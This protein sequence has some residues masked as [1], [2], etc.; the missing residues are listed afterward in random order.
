MIPGNVKSLLAVA[1]RLMRPGHRL[2]LLVTLSSLS[3]AGL[4]AAA[5]AE[6]RAYDAARN[7]FYGG[8][9]ERAEKEFGEFIKIHPDS[10]KVPEAVVLQAQCSYQQQ[11]LDEALALLRGR[12][13]GAGKLADEYRYWIAESLFQ[14]ADYAGAATAFAQV[15]SDFPNSA[16]RLAASL[17]EAYARFKAGELQQTVDLLSQPK[18]AFQQAAQNRMDDDLAVRGHLLL[19]EAYFGLKQFQRGQEVLIRLADRN[20]RP[21]LNWQRLYLLARLQSAGEQFDAALQTTTNLLGQLTA[22]TNLAALSLQADMS[23]LQA[24][25]FEQKGQMESAIQAYEKNL[26]PTVPMGRRR[27]AL[28]QT[29]RLTL[30]QNKIGE[31]G[32]RLESFVTQNPGDPLLDLLRLTLGELRL[33]EYYELA[34]EPRS[35]ATNLLQQAKTQFEQVIANANTQLVAKA[36]LDRGWYLWEL[37]RSDADTNRIS[38]SMLAFQAAADGLPRSEGQAVA[39][40]KRADCQFHLL[41]YAGAL[42]NYWA[43]VT[44]YPDLPKI[45]SDLVGLA[46]Y[47]IVRA[48]IQLGD[49]T[50][51]DQAVRRILADYRPGELNDRSLLLYGQALSRVSDPAGAR[52]FFADFVKRFPQSQMLPEVELAVARTYEE[53][54]NWAEAATLYDQWTA[55]RGE[56]VARPSVEFDRAWANSLAGNETNAYTLFTNFVA[57]FPAHPFAPQ[58]QYWVADYFYRLGGTNYVKAEENYQKVYQNTNWPPSELSFQ[59]RMM[60]GR[61]AFARQGYNAAANYFTSLINELAKLN[62]RPALLAEAYYALADTYVRN[63]E[64][65]PGSTNILDNYTEAIVALS[66]IP[67]EFPDKALV[68]LAWGQMGAY[69]AQLAALSHDPKDY[70]RATNAFTNALY[71][72]LA[73]PTCRGMAEVGLARV[74]EKQAQAQETKPADRTSLLNEAFTHYWYTVEGKNLRPG[75]PAD[76]FWVKEAAVSAARLAEELRQWDVASKWYKRLLTLLPPLRRIWELKLE[77]LEQLRAQTESAND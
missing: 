6:G 75:D 5:T 69:Y 37:G 46:L 29:V 36:Q 20:L 4:R 21:D 17:G 63:P 72:D 77:K 47:Q 53:E 10:E 7:M 71:S 54:G 24:E 15:L 12:L 43:V 30:A 27:Q 2:L 42:T 48:S 74:L 38:E 51:A 9:Y 28:Q 44:N 41:S 52:E 61:A 23:A 32:K 1:A 70:E 58:A 33:R 57:Q 66:R 76:P 39:R 62:P 16:R 49:S 73:D 26:N 64:A 34:E 25:V 14:K 56:H 31:A 65:G 55:K 50:N 11:K 68:P 40:F 45:Q 18:S 3:S 59:A 35:N 22:F 19:G 67:R 13:V 8:D 60:A